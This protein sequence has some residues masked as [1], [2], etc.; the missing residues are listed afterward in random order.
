MLSAKGVA[1]CSQLRQG[2]RDLCL[3]HFGEVDLPRT[4]Q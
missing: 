2:F 4:L 1:E 3:I